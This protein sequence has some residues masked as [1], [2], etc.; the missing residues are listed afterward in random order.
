M[1]LR[2]ALVNEDNPYRGKASQRLWCA[3]PCHARAVSL[4]RALVNGDDPYRRKASRRLWC[5]TPCPPLARGLGGNRRDDPRGLWWAAHCHAR[6]VGLRRALVNEDDPYRG[7]ASRRLWCV[8]PCRARAVSLRRALVRG[9]NEEDP[10][11]SSLA[12]GQ[13]KEGKE[14][15]ATPCPPLARGLGGNRRDDPRGLGGAAHCKSYSCQAYSAPV[16]GRGG[17]S[18]RRW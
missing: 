12:W 10:C 14:W 13:G 7:E 9:Q 4:R 17:S 11:P 16:T 3:T 18:S 2:R 6:A 15:C 5:A 1:G 8:T